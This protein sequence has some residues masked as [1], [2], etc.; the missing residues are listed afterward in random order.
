MSIGVTNLLR[1]RGF[2][3]EATCGR[4]RAA[5]DCGAIDPAEVLDGGV[6]RGTPA[7]RADSIEVDA[8]TLADVE[9][10]FDRQRETVEAFFDLPL[11]G[12]EGAGFLR[13][14]DGGGYQPHRDRAEDSWWPAAA[15]RRITVVVFLNADAFT[16]GMLRVW[17]GPV[18][19]PDA[20]PLA[21]HPEA[22]TLVA[23]PSDALHEVTPVRGGCRDTIVDWFLAA[24][25]LPRPAGD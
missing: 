9:G 1:I 21:I 5:M 2:L 10:R 22:G 8:E 18:D 14:R 24:H 16:G 4:V 6:A 7:R 13:Y 25:G 15:R 11:S 3:D 20:E 23:F 12:R 19:A 17:P